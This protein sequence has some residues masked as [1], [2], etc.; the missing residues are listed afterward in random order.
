L[1]AQ[2]LHSYRLLF[3]ILTYGRPCPGNL[4]KIASDGESN[5]D[6]SLKMAFGKA[7][8]AYGGPVMQ[9]QFSTLHG[10]GEVMGSKKVCPGVFVGGSS[11][12]IQE[13]RR[14]NLRP[15]EVLFV[16]GHA[17]WVPGQLTR[18][19]E[20]GVWYVAAASADLILRYAGA[21]VLKDDNPSDLWADILSCMGDKFVNIATAH[22]GRGD[23]RMLP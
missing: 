3:L 20:K 17:A 22:S 23:E 5:I 6:L 18:E 16:K 11:Q 21:P 12:L 8:V 19:I 14:N 2:N 4:I 7:T 15:T 9:D 10:F 13:V 1:P